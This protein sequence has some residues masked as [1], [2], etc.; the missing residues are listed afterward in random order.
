MANMWNKSCYVCGQ[1][2]ER[3]MLVFN[4]FPSF[5]SVQD[6]TPFL[7]SPTCRVCY[8]SS[9]KP[10]LTYTYIHT[11]TLFPWWFWTQSNWQRKLTITQTLTEKDIKPFIMIHNPISWWSPNLKTCYLSQ[12]KIFFIIPERDSLEHCPDLP[13]LLFTAVDIPN[14]DGVLKWK[15]VYR[16][17]SV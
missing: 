17:I 2:T 12:W 9:I 6:L 4:T 15:N 11:Q 16:D 5:L 10:S 13:A 3:N 1:E 14:Q 7:V 8:L